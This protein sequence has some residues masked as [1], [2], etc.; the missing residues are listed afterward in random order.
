LRATNW[1]TPLHDRALHRTESIAKPDLTFAV[2]FTSTTRARTDLEVF[3]VTLFAFPD[4]E[5][6]GLDPPDPD[7]PDP[8]PPDP[9]PPDPDPPVPDPPGADC[10]TAPRVVDG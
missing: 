1:T 7:P 5:L 6:L 9:D 3:E 2:D 4:P 10:G 8:D